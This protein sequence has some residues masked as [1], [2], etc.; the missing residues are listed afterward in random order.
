MR[1]G[2]SDTDGGSYDLAIVGTGFAGTFFLQRWL[3]HADAGARVVVLERGPAW[4]HARRIK[5]RR[6]SPI[7]PEQAAQW[8]GAKAKPWRFT[9]ALGG[10]TNCWWGNT[11]RMLPDDFQMHSLFGVGNDW[12]ISYSDLAPYYADAETTMNVAGPADAAYRDTPYPQPPHRLNEA[13]VALASAHPGQFHAMPTARARLA[14]E[15]RGACCANGVCHLCPVDAKFTIENGLAHVYADP[16]VTLVT[17]AEVLSVDVQAGRARGIVWSDSDGREHVVHADAVALA[18]NAIFNPAILLRSGVDHPLTGKRLHEQVG[19]RAEVRL[20]GLRG[21][22]GSTSV[23][24]MGTM[25]Y[26]DRERRR[27]RAACLIETWNVGLMRS[28]PGRWREV[29]PLRLVYEDLPL[30]SNAVELVPGDRSRPSA[31]FEAHSDYAE[32]AIRTASEDLER[33]FARLPVEDIVIHEEPE[34][35][36]GHIMGT[37]VMAADRTNGVV[38]ADCVHHDVRNLLVLGSST[39]VTGAPAN[40]S[41]TIA[42]Q[43]LRAADQWFGRKRQTSVGS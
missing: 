11:P 25:L 12:P 21:F 6:N 42:A 17:G 29:L 10:G 23:T 15:G 2:P 34:P 30:D 3:E 9:L 43:S 41:L 5:E 24:G 31:R 14:T 8:T 39:F 1:L 36:E 33:V 32:R 13:E 27:D 20:R 18:A 4:D 37:T 7:E 40:P 22:D 28:E 16:R 26:D 35:T 38:D 19:V